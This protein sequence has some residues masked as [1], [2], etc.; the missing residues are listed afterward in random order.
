MKK[1]VV[2]AGLAAAA[3]GAMKLLRGKDE[4]TFD[5]DRAY[6]PQPQAQI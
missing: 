5:A 4:D 2:L 1:I 3:F 6:E